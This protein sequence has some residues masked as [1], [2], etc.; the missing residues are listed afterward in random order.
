MQCLQWCIDVVLNTLLCSPHVCTGQ[1]PPTK[2]SKRGI[3]LVPESPS[4]PPVESV[5]ISAF[6]ESQGR[7]RP[8]QQSLERATL[9]TVPEESGSFNSSEPKVKP[10][11]TDPTSTLPPSRPPVVHTA[12]VA[13]FTSS[14]TSGISFDHHQE[15]PQHMGQCLLCHS[16]SN[17]FTEEVVALGVLVLGTCAHHAPDLVSFNLVTKIIPSISRSGVTSFKFPGLCFNFMHASLYTFFFFCL[18]RVVI[19]EHYYWQDSW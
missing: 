2:H 3:A 15:D 13:S 16:P 9:E 10:K 4:S 6:S 19:P 12:S 14:F 11:G 8:Q 1:A 7:P 5:A 18:D 17:V